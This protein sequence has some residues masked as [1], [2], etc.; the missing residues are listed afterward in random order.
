[1]QP[2]ERREEEEQWK[3]MEREWKEAR[4]YYRTSASVRRQHVKKGNMIFTV[5]PSSFI[6]IYSFAPISLA[7]VHAV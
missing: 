1:M 7:V 2:I 6:L 3:E 5:R 4:L